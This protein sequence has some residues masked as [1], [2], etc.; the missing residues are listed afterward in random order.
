MKEKLKDV[1]VAK[2]NTDHGRLVDYILEI[3]AIVD[4]LRKRKPQPNDLVQLDKV[5]RDLKAYTQYHF[6]AEEELFARMDYPRKEEH[7]KE[8]RQ[9]ILGLDELKSKVSGRKISYSVDLQ[10]FLLDW[11]FNHI[12]RHDLK[13]KEFFNSKGIS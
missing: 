9:L 11:L 6:N 8:H 12:N 4:Q 1:G 13:Y 7:M 5:F 2:F 3:N 10:F